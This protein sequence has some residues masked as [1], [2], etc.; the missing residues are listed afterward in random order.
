M[1]G[2]VSSSVERWSL[3][4]L[5]SWLGLVATAPAGLGAGLRLARE[6]HGEGL[7][8]RV[9][10]GVHPGER[11]AIYA[12]GYLDRLLSCLRT[13]YPALRALLGASI[14]DAFALDYL[15]A[16]PP[17]HFSLFA[18]GA[19]FA[20]HLERTCP[21]PDV[22]PHERRA[23][24]RLP[25]DLARVERA[26]LEATRAPG[27]ERAANREHVAAGFDLLL[28][29]Q[30]HICVTPCLRVVMLE[31]DVRPF[32]AAID[33][34]E[35]AA[36]PEPREMSLAVSRVNYRITWT[37]VC[38]WQRDALSSSRKPRPLLALARELG[39]AVGQEPGAML[40]ELLVWLPVAAELGMLSLESAHVDAAG[41]APLVSAEPEVQELDV[42]L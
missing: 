31:H 5:Q 29:E 36:V 37:E 13:D 40:A 35:V 6:R 1:Q 22:V 20:E 24:L 42:P 18:L 15:R 33:R 19:G 26:R 32:L 25:V 17:R 16:H 23:L 9:P 12:R 2:C 30:L 7:P 8:V 10:A 4:Q 14:F 28:S 21:P 38:A 34:G 3:A 39:Q 27:C 41:A 11:L